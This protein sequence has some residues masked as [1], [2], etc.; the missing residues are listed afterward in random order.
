MSITFELDLVRPLNKLGMRYWAG[1]VGIL[2]I[3]GI[4]EAEYTTRTG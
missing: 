1:L 4:V 3:L 2:L